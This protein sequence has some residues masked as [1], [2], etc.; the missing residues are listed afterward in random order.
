MARFVIILIAFGVLV[1]LT[2]T[3]NAQPNRNK[4]RRQKNEPPPLPDDQKL[5]KLHMAFV[6]DATKL[7]ETYERERDWDKAVAVYGEI[8]KLVPQYNKAKQKLA[9]I[10][11]RI[12]NKEKHQTT[13][14]SRK[15]W[16][17]S[18]VIVVEGKP[19]TIRAAGS[20][21]FTLKAK[22]TPDGIPIPKDLREFDLGAL[23]GYIDTGDPKKDKPFMIGAQRSFK[24][25][26]TGKLYLKM[27]DSDPK[28]NDGTIAVEV[29]GDFRKK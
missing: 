12:A 23:I 9:E 8:I 7:A 21:T 4:A 25:K 19:V 24:A 11:A 13:V 2:S 6:R 18:G 20:W 22:L 26:Q 17:Y 15:D 3:V 1:E 10:N 27:H 5:L 16:Q 29:V 14:D 28:D